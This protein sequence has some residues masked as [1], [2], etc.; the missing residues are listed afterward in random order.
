LIFVAVA[1]GAPNLE[2]VL[3]AFPLGAVDRG[4]GLPFVRAGG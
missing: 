3:A 2:I 1:E 4:G